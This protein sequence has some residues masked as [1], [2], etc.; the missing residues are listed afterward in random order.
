MSTFGKPYVI[1][2][3]GLCGG[4][5]VKIYGEHLFSHDESTIYVKEMLEQ[6]HSVLIEEKLFGQEFSFITFT[7]G[8]TCLDCPPLQDYK[9]LYNND[10]GPNTGSMG[11]Y[12]YYDHE[13]QIHTLPFLS[14]HDI[15]SASHVNRTIIQHLN[16]YFQNKYSYSFKYRGILY[17]SYIKTNDNKLKIIEFN[18]R[19]GD[20]EAIN[21]FELMESD[22]AELFVKLTQNNL[23]NY[24]L[25]F[26][27]QCSISKYLV[28][29]NYP[30]NSEPSI[31][32]FNNN[33]NN[34]FKNIVFGNNHFENSNLNISSRGLAIIA[35]D[36]S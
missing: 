2:P 3:T 9:R 17:G 21:I 11:C 7:D 27:K 31:I 29:Q 16:D 30:Y 1:K 26:K 13:S 15:E 24:Q 18:A 10:E 20:P 23:Q 32:A 12:T 28:S 6:G 22:A 4:K 34:Y 35:C 5:G 8:Y 19:L 14:T 36:A 25:K 33:I